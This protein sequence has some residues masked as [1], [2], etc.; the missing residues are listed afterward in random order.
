[1]NLP[2]YEAM[3]A[4]LIDTDDQQ[5]TRL[6]RIMDPVFRRPKFRPVV[7]SAAREDD[8]IAA[9]RQWF[10]TPFSRHFSGWADQLEPE[11]RDALAAYSKL[12]TEDAALIEAE[13]KLRLRFRAATLQIEA[14]WKQIVHFLP[15]IFIA[16]LR[17]IDDGAL[18][19]DAAKELAR[20]LRN[21]NAFYVT[22]SL[23]RQKE[24]V[25]Y[26]LRC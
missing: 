17:R 4:A 14:C 13:H 8:I 6:V 22:H 21:Y 7:E 5:V 16:A 11:L 12:G 1:M 18:R 26:H 25:Q 24:A 9:V 10:P 23:E 15:F 19:G 20:A 3:R 2:D